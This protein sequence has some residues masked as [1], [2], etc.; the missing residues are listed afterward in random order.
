[1]NKAEQLF[2]EIFNK[3]KKFSWDNWICKLIKEKNP[4]VILYIGE[5]DSN[6][7]IR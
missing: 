5:D 4:T 1:M 2:I 6:G 3:C 7:Y